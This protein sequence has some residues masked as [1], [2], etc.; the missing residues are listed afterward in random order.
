LIERNIIHHTNIGIELA[1][2]HSGRATSNITVR[3]NFVYSNTQVGIAFGGYDTKRGSTENCVI[4]NNT[5][6]NNATQGDWGA[7]LYVQF[8]TRNNI[9]E[10]NIFYANSARK[11][12]E[13]WSAVMTGNV[14]DYNLYFALGG[15]TNG[16]FIWK[17]VTYTTFADY[18]AGSGN[19]LHGMAGVDP[20]FVNLAT[21]DL[22]LQ[23]NSPAIDRGFNLSQSGTTDIDG[24]VR[25]QGAAI[26][27]GADEVR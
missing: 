14:V 3:N 2:E 10:N 23:S 21:P 25:I 17:N 22:H 24:Q 13:S 27:L 12:I 19:D 20:L 15:G 6:Y 7:E 8:D 11:F 16:S 18:Q 26:D 4:V 1:S 5:F 9:V